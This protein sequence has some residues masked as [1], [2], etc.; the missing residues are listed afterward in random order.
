GALARPRR[1]RSRRAGRAGNTGLPLTPYETGLVCKRLIRYGLELEVVADR[2]GLGTAYVDGL[3]MLVGGPKSIRDA[4][5]DDRISATEAVKLLKTHGD[6]AVEVL[7]QMLAAAQAQGRNKATAK[8]AP[9][10]AIKRV[11]KKHSDSLY[12]AA[13]TVRQDPG[14]TSLAVETR[15]LLDEL[16]RTSTGLKKIWRLRTPTR[17]KRNDSKLRCSLFSP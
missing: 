9:G 6:K 3:L 2:M 1:S 5:I 8:H 10:A 11:V 13:K 4:V 12:Q 17:L 15:L 16:L 7:E 14:Y